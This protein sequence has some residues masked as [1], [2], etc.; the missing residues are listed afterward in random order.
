MNIDDI[1]GEVY[2]EKGC[3]LGKI[4]DWPKLMF[5]DRVACGLLKEYSV[6]RLGSKE[7]EYFDTID[8][9][10]NYLRTI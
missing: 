4:S 5:L 6:W 8:E 9:C 3:V 1:E 2:E 7:L 10:K